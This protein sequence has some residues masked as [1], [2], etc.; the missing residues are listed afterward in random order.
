MSR[1]YYGVHAYR[2]VFDPTRFFGTAE[3]ARA[4]DRGWAAEFVASRSYDDVIKALA[5][6]NS[7]MKAVFDWLDSEIPHGGPIEASADRA[8]S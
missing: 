8:A 1:A 5:E 6:G 3:E 2:S 7:G 4:H